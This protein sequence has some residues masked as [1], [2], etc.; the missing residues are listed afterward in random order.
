MFLTLKIVSYVHNMRVIEDGEQ[1]TLHL[2]VKF[3]TARNGVSYQSVNDEV[4]TRRYE[5]E[6]HHSAPATM[7]AF[8]VL[9]YASCIRY[10]GY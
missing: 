3:N 9:L 1:V 6:L 5:N 8:V 4:R 7:S 2:R 10:G